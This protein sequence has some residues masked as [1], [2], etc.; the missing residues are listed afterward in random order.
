[1]GYKYQR[2]VQNFSDNLDTSPLIFNIVSLHKENAILFIYLLCLYLNWLNILCKLRPAARLPVASSRRHWT[3]ATLLDVWHG[4][5]QGVIDNAI[6]EWRRRIRACVWAKGGHFE[7]KMW[8]C[9]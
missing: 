3:E 1:M 8:K 4:M 7:Q 5:E 6:D 2:E 9:Q